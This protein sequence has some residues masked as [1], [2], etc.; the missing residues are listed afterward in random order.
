[1][2][3]DKARTGWVLASKYTD[4]DTD[5]DIFTPRRPFQGLCAEN[6]KGD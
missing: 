1:V 2:K 4:P 3:T 6:D 5:P